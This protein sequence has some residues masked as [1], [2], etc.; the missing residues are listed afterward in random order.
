MFVAFST[1]ALL[2]ATMVAPAAYALPTCP[3]ANCERLEGPTRYE[4]ALEVA[5]AQWAPT[6]SLHPVPSEVWIATGEDFPDALA[7]GAQAG[8]RVAPLLLVKKNEI[9]PAVK[10][11]LQ[12]FAS[13]GTSQFYIAG[14]ADVV[15][16]GVR[17][18][19]LA[20]PGSPDV[21]R[22]S[23]PDRYA[24]AAEIYKQRACSFEV[25]LATG[26]NFPDALAGAA[27]AGSFNDNFEGFLGVGAILLANEDGVPQATIDALNECSPITNAVTFL[28]GADVLPA[29][30]QA[31]IAAETS[32]TD[33]DR[34]S[35]PTRYETAV[36]IAKQ[37]TDRPVD[38]VYLAVG[39]NF[40]DALAGS[41][42]AAR[43]PVGAGGGSP[44]LL[45]RKNCIPATVDSYLR[46]LNGGAG[47]TK[48]VLLGGSDVLSDAAPNTVC[49]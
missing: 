17:T 34:L 20:L 6:G 1:C 46:S 41:P 13:A 14:G 31:Q 27:L 7:A 2:A 40:P 12:T 26:R 30:L 25:F 21:D 45:A 19:L 4:T 11:L 37:F 36:D 15:S 29:S 3:G 33:F 5:K 22:I 23:G 38:K 48:L 24:T 28:G 49:P 32:V 8:V 10:T 39:D 18:E 42:A 35:G 47:P 16:E 43:D 9:P 44:I